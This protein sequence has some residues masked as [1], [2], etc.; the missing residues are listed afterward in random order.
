M[1][2]T[3]SWAVYEAPLLRL[4]LSGSIARL[5]PSIVVLCFRGPVADDTAGRQIVRNRFCAK[6]EAAPP[7]VADQRGL[8]RRVDIATQPAH[9]NVDQVRVRNKFVVPDIF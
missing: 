7:D 6:N 3:C 5:H 8:I 2:V 1:A 9:V 4:L